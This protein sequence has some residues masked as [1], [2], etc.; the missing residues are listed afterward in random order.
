MTGLLDTVVPAGHAEHLLAVVRETL[1]N[2]ARHAHATAVEVTVETDSSRVR[3]RIADNGTGIDPA[4]TRRSGLDNLRR[5]A[6]DLGGGLTLTPN[7][8]TGTVVEWT[9]PLSAPAGA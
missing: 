8:P 2:A 4:V 5:R 6:T 7:E 3:L 9:V 1:S